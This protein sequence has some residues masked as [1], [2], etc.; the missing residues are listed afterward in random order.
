MVT[1]HIGAGMVAAA[2]LWTFDAVCVGAAS[3]G[4]A[5]KEEINAAVKFYESVKADAIKQKAYCEV[6]QGLEMMIADPKKLAEGEQKIA[7]AKKTLGQDFVNAQVLQTRM[8]MHSDDAKRYS[9]ARETA[10]QACP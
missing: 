4:N 2:V 7:A 9:I 5:T 3:A 1:R 6:K 8:D 10:G